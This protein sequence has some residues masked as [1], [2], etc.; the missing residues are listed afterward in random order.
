MG[1]DCVSRAMEQVTQKLG[2]VPHSSVLLITILGLAIAARRS[3]R[4]WIA[5]Q[6]APTEP[7]V[8]VPRLKKTIVLSV[9]GVAYVGL[10]YLVA[11]HSEAYAIIIDS[12]VTVVQSISLVCVSA[13]RPLGL[14]RSSM[15]TLRA[16]L[17]WPSL[18]VRAQ[19]HACS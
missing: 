7:K 19:F 3:L 13:G 4:N 12:I 10:V 8:E 16:A 17:A 1:I 9:L 6:Q 5:V 14:I 15:H 11:F 18:V 2:E